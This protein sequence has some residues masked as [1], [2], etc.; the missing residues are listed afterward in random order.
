MVACEGWS[1]PGITDEKIYYRKVQKRFS[2]TYSPVCWTKSLNRLQIKSPLCRSEAI[3]QNQPR[4]REQHKSNGNWS[5]ASMQNR[6]HKNIHFLSHS[7]SSVIRSAWEK[8]GPCHS[9]ALQYYNMTALVS[10]HEKNW[11]ASKMSDEGGHLYALS[12]TDWNSHA[13]SPLTCLH[14]FLVG[15]VEFLC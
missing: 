13:Y 1:V 15:S 2:E 9:P 12:S 14:D 7:L 6:S 5:A 4:A 3:T 8:Q 11:Q 10:L